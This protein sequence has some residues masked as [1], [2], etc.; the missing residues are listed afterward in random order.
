MSTFRGRLAAKNQMTIPPQMQRELNLV[1]GDELEFSVEGNR[2]VRVD[3]LKPV[4]A[5][6]LGNDILAA[7]QKRR[8]DSKEREVSATELGQLSDTDSEKSRKKVKIPPAAAAV[9]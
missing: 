5:D 4:P 7:L 3:V 8:E 2:I 1:K 6:L 9:L